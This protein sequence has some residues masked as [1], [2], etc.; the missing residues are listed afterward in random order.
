[1]D[2]DTKSSIE[3]LEARMDMLEAA[4]I[5]LGQTLYYFSN[6]LAVLQSKTEREFAAYFDELDTLWEQTGSPRG[7]AAPAS[8]L[9]LVISNDNASYPHGA[10]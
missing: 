10:A 8:H 6:K 4:F 5:N 3:A 2:K 7:A 9:Q 1:M